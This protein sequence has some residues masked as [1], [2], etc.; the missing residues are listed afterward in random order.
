M[1]EFEVVASKKLFVLSNTR[2]AVMASVELLKTCEADELPILIALVHKRCFRHFLEHSMYCLYGKGCL[3]NA[4]HNDADV[5]FTACQ[6]RLVYKRASQFLG[7]VLL[8]N[9][10]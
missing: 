7:V 1:L 3:H 5:A 2:T 4:D 10:F 8:C 6:V 9:A